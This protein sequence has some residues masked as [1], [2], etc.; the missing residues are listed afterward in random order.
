MVGVRRVESALLPRIEG[1]AI[2]SREGMIAEADG[3]FPK[4]LFVP[5][6]QRHYRSS[7]ARASGV[8]NGRYS[9]EVESQEKDRKRLVLTRRVAGLAPHPRRPAAVLW[10]PAGASFEAAWDRLGGGGTAAVLGGTGVFA[11]FLDEIGYDFFYLSRTSARVQNGRPIF[12]GVG[13]AVRP[14]DVL[15]RKGYTVRETRVL[16]AATGTIL[17]EWS[18]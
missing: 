1:Y 15:R 6:D 10:N 2:V 11:L 16:D 12:P 8:V 13:Q 7:L 9:T 14:E 18:R 3:S 4:G 5:A 17:Q